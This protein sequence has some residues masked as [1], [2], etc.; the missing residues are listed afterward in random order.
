MNSETRSCQ[1]CKQ[2][3]IIEAEDFSF[4]EKIKVPPPTWCPEC[5]FQRRL[6]WR[7]ERNLYH[8]QCELCNRNFITMYSADKPF[9]VYCPECWW[10]DKWDSLRYGRDYDF[11]RPFFEQF[12]EL[13]LRVPR[14]SLIQMDV[15]DL[16]L[17]N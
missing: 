6:L 8:R 10:S 16:P 9:S 13:M 7:N 15:V 3:F 12:K 2:D 11:S 17:T 5:R 4:Y 14:M 1:N